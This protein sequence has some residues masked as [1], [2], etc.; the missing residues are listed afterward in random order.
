MKKTTTE[1]EYAQIPV[2]LVA[3][4][5]EAQAALD[6]I[7]RRIKSGETTQHQA[8]N[9]V[10]EVA[11]RLRRQHLEHLTNYIAKVINDQMTTPYAAAIILRANVFPEGSAT[12]DAVMSTGDLSDLIT[13]NAVSA[14]DPQVTAATATGVIQ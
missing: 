4:R 12:V 6:D 10:L 2:S 14:D 7:H 1:E 9:E 3:A 5:E 11:Q 13:I 8:M